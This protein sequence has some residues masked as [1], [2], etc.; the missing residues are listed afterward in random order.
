MLE[1][2]ASLFAVVEK[3]PFEVTETG[4]GEFEVQMRIYFVDANEKP[5][6]KYTE[7]AL[8]F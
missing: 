4:W 1:F 3:A 8:F 6:I 2:F 5:V 7:F